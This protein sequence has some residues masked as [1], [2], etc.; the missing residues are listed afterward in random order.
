MSM[1][2][3]IKQAVMLCTSFLVLFSAEAKKVKLSVNMTGQTINPNGLHVSGD[4]QTLAGYSGGD[5]NS[6]TTPLT[7]DPNN[8]QI[9]SVVVDI[10]AGRKYEFKFVNGD[11]FYEVE[12]VPEES[13]VGYDFNDNRWFYLDSLANDTTLIGPLMFAG[14]APAGKKLMRMKVDMKGQ[15]SISS[16]G[17]H[18]A[19]TF[20]D[21]HYSNARMY[22]FINQVYEYQAYADSAASVSYHFVNGNTQSAAEELPTSC[23]VN[24]KRQLSLQTDL[25]LDS[26]C[27]SNCE[28]CRST[29]GINEAISLNNFTISPNPALEEITISGLNE[30]RLFQLS[31]YDAGGRMVLEKN[32]FNNQSVNLSGVLFTQGIYMVKI[33]S[34]NLVATKKLMLY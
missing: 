34:D 13:R 20:N 24:G 4:F 18:V 10:P 23:A 16:N 19:G 31:I 8:A 21:Y 7:V 26:V 15:T 12:F 29:T 30:T 32:V 5:W 3:F 33:Q 27:F 25:V 28:L 11:L 1:K 9:F 17:V 6:A 14:N 2:N 22:S